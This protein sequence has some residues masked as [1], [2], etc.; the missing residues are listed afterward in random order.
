M[1]VET[2]YDVEFPA[3]EKHDISSLQETTKDAILNNCDIGVVLLDPNGIV[4]EWNNWMVHHAALDRKAALGRNFCALFPGLT[5]GEI[6]DAIDIAFNSELCSEFSDFSENQSLPLVDNQKLP[7]AKHIIV[8]PVKVKAD[9]TYCL[10]QI[11]DISRAVKRERQL[12]A[13][14]NI[15]EELAQKLSQEKERAQVTLESIADAVITTD[16]EGKV[17][18]MNK[19]AVKLTGWPVEKALNRPVSQIFSVIH[20]TTRTR[21]PNPVTECLRYQKVVSNDE[22]LILIDHQGAEYAI[23]ESAAPIRGG[24]DEQLGAVLVFRDVTSARKLSSQ[25]NWQ[26][27]HDPLTGL[28]N[29]R[30]FENQLNHLVAS[31]KPNEKTHAVMYLDL[32]RFKIVNDTCGHSAG[33]ELLR[34]ITSVIVKLLRSN[35]VL[36]RL[37]GDEF[38]IL[39]ERCQPDDALRI[40]NLLRLEVQK[41]RFGWQ[42][43]TFSVGVSIGLTQITGETS[44]SEEIMSAA[45]SACYA[46]KENGRNQV[47]IHEV[48]IAKRSI[49]QKEMQWVHRIQSALD[50]DRFELYVQPIVGLTNHVEYPEHY[51]VLLRM[52]ESE[53]SLISPGAFIPAAERFNM[54]PKIDRWVIKKVCQSMANLVSQS[55]RQLPLFSVNLSGTS[56]SDDGFMED[57]LKFLHDSN[58][59]S[60]KLCFEITETSAIANMTKAIHFI[61]RLKSAGCYFSL[62][63]FG[64]GLSSFSYLKNLPVDFLKI[65]GHFVKDI[66]HDPVDYAFVDSIN[67]IGHVMGITTIAEFVEN[68]IILEAVKTIG[69]DCGQGFG[70]QKP[71]QFLNLIESMTAKST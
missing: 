67:Q 4:L 10:L 55:T 47:Y 49:H 37:G 15:M 33:D 1:T 53:N 12:V 18:S 40:A 24:D 61:N 64:S 25:L 17:H 29:R 70:I 28:L 41:Y 30:E 59:P 9:Q 16:A 36:A 51:E 45:D 50:E 14:S 22:D 69:V 21:T 31:A 68:D 71:F 39:L 11:T 57:A 65:D 6:S 42:G 58:I 62:D 66:G 56:L 5:N 23:T 32:D 54:M 43:K 26:A 46:A 63:D 20:E 2:E 52:V 3:V 60:N 35:D 13:Q 44:D 8:K 34:Q 48:S 7:V 38:G 27:S 19:V